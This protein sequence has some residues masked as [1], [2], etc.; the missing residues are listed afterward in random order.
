MSTHRLLLLFLATASVL[1]ASICVAD[2]P[3]ETGVEPFLGHPLLEARRV[4]KDERFPNIVV[5]TKG[6]LLATWGRPRIRVRRSEDNG[7]TW[8]G[9]ISIAK[10]IHGGGTTVDERTGDIL[11][12]VESEHPPAPLT[13]YR[14]KDDGKTWQQSPVIIHPDSS[15]KMPSMHMN[16][17]GITLQR[18]KH[19]GR[20]L[21][22]SRHYGKANRPES[23]W[24][25]HFTNAIYSDDG[26][27]TWQTSEPFPENGTGEAT[28]AEL[29]DGRIY[30]NSR[31][32]WAPDGRNPRRRWTAWSDDGGASWKD[33]RICEAL[34]DGPQNT[35]Y[36]CMGG[37]ARLPIRGRDVLVYSN[38]DHP[39]AR[40][41]G[42]VWVSFDG[43][44]S[45]PLK[46]IVEKGAFAYSSLTAGRPGTVTQGWIFPALRERR[47]E[48][49]ALQLELAPQG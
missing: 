47:L 5:S 23:L 22:P 38:C 25:T 21:R 8:G 17:H 48:G 40:Q 18:G 1:A 43:G 9:E 32:H 34:P 2:A 36:G 45:W 28:L 16:E 11:V 27:K 7:A 13:V 12:F 29:T 42:A 44:R 4:F 26:G 19:R 37:L 31:R 20:L 10:G 30:Y 49:R 33:A 14:S 24:P 15:G 41:N 3:Q 46:R 6:A 35:N 39:N